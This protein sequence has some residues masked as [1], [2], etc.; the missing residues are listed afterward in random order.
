MK[1]IFDDCLLPN[2]YLDSNVLVYS[3]YFQQVIVI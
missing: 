2:D 3:L 1:T